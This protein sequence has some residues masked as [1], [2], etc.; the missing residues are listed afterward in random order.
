MGRVEHSLLGDVEERLMG[1]ET[2]IAWTDHTFNYWIGC[3]KISPAC[4]RC[5]AAARDQRFEGGKHWGPGAPRRLTSRAN[6]H[7]LRKWQAYAKL[8]GERPWVF[9]FSLADVFDNEVDPAWR[10]SFWKEV[11]VC[12]CLRIQLVT[13][14]VGNAPDMLPDNWEED[15][16]HCGIISTVVTSEEYRRDMPK[17]MAMKYDYHTRWIGLSIEPQ[18]EEIRLGNLG[19]RLD[20]VITGGESDQV[21]DGKMELGRPYDIDWARALIDDG[22]REGVPV[23]VKQIGATPQNGGHPMPLGGK[24]SPGANP[25]LWPQD[26]RVREMPR[27]Y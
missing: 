19:R 4:D 25:L 11:R 22:A 6:R 3:T 16:Q 23:F 12:D 9:C 14:R 17:L 2:S 15:F 5:Y 7:S 8:S 20:W 18:L 1:E 27:V 26:I 13:K 21:V 24:R 10:K